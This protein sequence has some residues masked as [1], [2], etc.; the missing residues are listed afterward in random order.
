MATKGVGSDS[1][2]HRWVGLGGLPEMTRPIHFVP[3]EPDWDAYF[4]FY[5][6]DRSLVLF[7]KLRD[8]GVMSIFRGEPLYSIPSFPPAIDYSKNRDL[9]SYKRCVDE[10][11]EWVAFKW[12]PSVETMLHLVKVAHRNPTQV[13][14]EF[15]K[16]MRTATW[17]TDVARQKIILLSAESILREIPISA[18]RIIHSIQDVAGEVSLHT[19]AFGELHQSLKFGE[20]T[21]PA[22]MP[23]G[24]RQLWVPA[25]TTGRGIIHDTNNINSSLIGY[26]DLIVRDALP[27]TPPSV[28]NAAVEKFIERLGFISFE[29]ARAS[30]TTASKFLAD[31]SNKRQVNVIADDIP[32]LS[33]PL[34]M[35][36]PVFRCIYEL[37]LNAIK[38]SDPQKPGYALHE[39]DAKDMS[40]RHAFISGRVEG[41][42]LYVTVE[43]NGVGMEDVEMAIR[44][45]RRLRPDLA[46]GTG[47]GLGTVC[48]LARN[49]GGN[50]HIESRVGIGTKA[51]V[52]FDMSKATDTNG[53][54]PPGNGSGYNHGNGYFMPPTMDGL[55]GTS[56]LSL[57]AGTLAFN[58]FAA[59]A[60]ACLMPMCRI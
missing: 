15:M 36:F 5:P 53:S 9:V 56:A 11:E 45:G 17:L 3:D 41:T 23:E 33:L 18:I 8:M 37:V 42:M 12:L 10:L 47:R 25:L 32:D 20:N 14:A 44:D 35:R 50:L 46:D 13:T 4:E 39:S 16:V 19:R 60:R 34:G 43:D 7:P 28:V 48:S 2:F 29:N 38:Y 49:L 40:F 21:L 55:S 57:G 51:T 6:L 52:S 1:D 30:S 59:S 27:G 26:A 54:S 24:L 31:R 22:D 58:A